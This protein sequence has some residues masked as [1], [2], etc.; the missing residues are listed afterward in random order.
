MPANHHIGIV[1]F[2]GSNCDHDAF[3]TIGRMMGQPVR[4]IWHREPNIG[5]PSAVVVPGGFSYGDYL[6]SGAIARFAPVMDSLVEF[7]RGGRPVLG[8]CNGFQ[9]LTEAKMLPGVLL[10]N[11]GLRF[12]CREVYLRVERDDT[13]FTR[14]YLK[15]QVIK[16]PIAHNE[17]NFYLTDD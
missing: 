5:E 14:R 8:I 11:I 3:D 13:I 6:R 16:I 7:A 2:P 1:V 17:G 10:R 12:I 15:G 9:I 4:A